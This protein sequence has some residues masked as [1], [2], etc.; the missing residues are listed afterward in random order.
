METAKE[1]LGK[2][3]LQEQ[4]LA[5]KLER[6]NEL[7]AILNIDGNAVETQ[8]AERGEAAEEK[9]IDGTAEP[10]RKPSILDKIK[11]IKTEQ[12]EKKSP[13]APSKNRNEELE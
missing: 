4:E 7:N 1:E 5:E 3:F 13:D 6:L 9:E 10:D 2:P 11:E 8:D 12:D